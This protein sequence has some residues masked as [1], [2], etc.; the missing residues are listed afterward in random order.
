MELKIAETQNRIQTIGKL[1]RVISPT[2]DG[3]LQALI[4]QKPLSEM[5]YLERWRI[6]SA[7]KSQVVEIME[8]NVAEIEKEYRIQA[9]ELE[10]LKI[11]ETAEIIRSADVIGITTTGAAKQKPLLEHLK[12]KIG[13]SPCYNQLP[14]TF[15]TTI[16]CRLLQWW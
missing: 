6:Y 8:A 3:E 7:W 15:Q 12:C 4:K 9:S 2:D 13:E 14:R 16:C 10:D 5:N 11:T 1:L